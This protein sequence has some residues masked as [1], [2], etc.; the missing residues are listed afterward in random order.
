M[1][2]QVV[3]AMNI[4][5]RLWDLGKGCYHWFGF[6]AVLAIASVAGSIG[7]FGLAAMLMVQAALHPPFSELQLMIVGIRFFGISRSVLRYLDRYFS[8]DAT[9]RLLEKLRGKFYLAIEP[10]FP[11]HFHRYRRGD[12]LQRMVQD[13]ETLQIFF[14]QTRTVKV[15]ALFTGAMLFLLASLCFNATALIFACGFIVCAIVLPHVAQVIYE[16]RQKRI[17]RRSRLFSDAFCDFTLGHTEIILYGQKAER[18]AQLLRLDRSLSRDRRNLA[19]AMGGISSFSQTFYFLSAYVFLYLVLAGHGDPT[20]LP[21]IPA[22]LVLAFLAAEEALNPL[23]PSSLRREDCKEAG[24]RLVEIL[25]AKP[26]IS[27][28]YQELPTTGG[29][30]LDCIDITFSYPE[31]TIPTLNRISFRIPENGKIAIVGPSG[32]GK[33]SI[34][35]LL[36][37]FYEFQ[38]GKMTIGGADVQ[39]FS[40]ESVR[41]KF[42]WSSQTPDF[43][44]GTILENLMVHEENDEKLSWAA[45]LM[46]TKNWIE[47]LPD[48]YDTCIGEYG[49]KL[50]AGQRKRIDLM[51]SLLKNAPILLWDEPLQHLDPG[52]AER[53]W[54][55]IT[56]RISGKTMLVI[57]HRL[58]NMERFDQ[59]LV[60]RRGNLVQTGRH[61]ELIEQDG[62]YRM[63]WLQQQKSCL[64]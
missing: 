17:L 59:I 16:R 33:S 52:N 23:L 8:H 24:R 11:E 10:I 31:Q 36:L 45:E 27:P 32:S 58:L 34:F 53:I 40:V 20:M 46:Q 39:K 49:A 3:R 35:S 48:R 64:R 15:V 12:L 19:V 43:F 30:G 57:S 9:F 38:E 28:Q 2:K 25:D 61:Q 60:L 22:A 41:S 42:A 5:R 29:Y 21:T 50:S 54:E 44:H 4:D 51:R 55:G 56:N 1:G 7:L 6:T 13:I 63:M 18:M 62:L 47:S 37:R 26:T 14:M